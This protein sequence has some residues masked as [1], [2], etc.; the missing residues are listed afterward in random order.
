MKCP[1]CTTE[2][3]EDREACYQC[4]K[5]I[6]MLRLIINKARHHYN[7]ALE[8][9]ERQR[10]PEALA[11]L[12][13][14]LELD[15]S[16]VPAHVVKGTIYAK[17][18]KFDEAERCWQEA[19]A[20]DPHILKAYDYLDKSHV[21]RQAIPLLRRL[22]WAIVAAAA[23]TVL[24]AALIA[25]LLR[26]TSDKAELRRINTEIEKGNYGAAFDIAQHL[27]DSARSPDVRHAARLLGYT[28]AQRYESAATDM[29]TLLLENKPIE[30]HEFYLRIIEQ[31]TPPDLY[32]S[33]LELLDRKAVAQAMGLLDTWRREFEKDTLTF[34]ELAQ[35]A[36]RLGQVFPEAETA[37]KVNAMLAA[38]R[39]SWVN[40]TL[41]AAKQTS[42][43]QVGETL[44]AIGRL[45][46]LAKRVPESRASATSATAQ[47]LAAAVGQVG[48]R[49]D[50]AL[51]A[52]DGAAL[53]SALDD[54]ER[55]SAVGQTEAAGPL[56]QKALAGLRRIETDRFKARL[57]AATVADIPQ[58]DSW[59]TSFE[60]MT[61]VTVARDTDVSGVLT[62]A[63]RRLAVEVIA[64]CTDRD[65]RLQQKKATEAEARWIAERAE[66]ALRHAQV[67]TWRYTRDSV[68]ICAGM[69]FLQLGK[70]QEALRWFDR[71]E[72]TYPQSAY[73]TSS[74]R[75]R[76]Q[77]EKG[78]K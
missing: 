51:T 73:L 78:T 2:N 52:K 65:T 1:Y 50:K 35:K 18:E 66:F 69:A 25:W 74:R 75:Y 61:S 63:Q 6:S 68:M 21:A 45:N 77:I 3:R 54:L 4:G 22:R 41:A 34:D 57:A 32:K 23:I 49:I 30:A 64:W 11:E 33:Q 14:C 44:T 58:L 55:L 37:V 13:H 70:N 67:K 7:V 29:L 12:D 38:A 19:L 42:P 15:H 72:K 47:I 46:D 59:I 36:E 71:L 5:D 39:R 28:I 53:R 10:Y 27:D 20:L 9:A 76:Q 62:R 8:H 26:P 24:F 43:I 40:R 48:L 31:H 17:M 16:L 56:A 60:K